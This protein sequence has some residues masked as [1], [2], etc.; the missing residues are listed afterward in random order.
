[1]THIVLK[2]LYQRKFRVQ[3]DAEITGC[4]LSHPSLSG[5]TG[6]T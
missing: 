3:Q 6:F 2:L 1:M 4:V 5:F